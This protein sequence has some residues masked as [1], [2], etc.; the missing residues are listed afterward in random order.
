MLGH[1]GVGVSDEVGAA[2]TSFEPGDRMLISC[3][4]A[5]GRCKP[6]RKGMCSHCTTGGWIRG[7]RFDGT[8]A[9]FLRLP[10]ADTSPYPIL[11]GADE[12]ALVMRQRGSRV[13]DARM[14][15]GVIQIGAVMAAATLLTIDTRLPG[16]LLEGTR[17][18]T[19]AR[20]AGFT[21]LVFAQLFNCFNA[22]SDTVSAFSHPFVNGWLWSAV[23]LSALLQVAV[24]NLPF[25]NT[26]FGTVPLLSEDSLLCVTM[27]SS[28][29]W[30][31]EARKL[32]GRRRAATSD[33]SLV[34]PL[35]RTT[36]QKAPSNGKKS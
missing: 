16:G 10:H 20:T 30:F 12:E 7:H 18:L 34:L 35:S 4:T 3:I 27:A 19:A 28:V 11:A 8:Q 5:C 24:V 32:V 15:S 36:D 31:T 25:L 13:I 6:C 1:E 9:E 17:D 26:A 29:L 14:W 22:S 33:A 21:V 23:A 2:V